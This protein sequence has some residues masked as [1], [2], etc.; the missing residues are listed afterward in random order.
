VT[1]RKRPALPTYHPAEEQDDE[2][3]NSF[4]C[5]TGSPFEDEVQTFIRTRALS[6]ALADGEGY[7]L[8]LFHDD[9]RLIGVAGH[10]P[11]ILI[12][13]TPGN[14]E[15]RAYEAVRLSVLA[16]GLADQ[17]RVL[18]DGR[19]LSDLVMETLIAEA[20]G[21]RSSVLV[22]GVVARANHRSIALCER[23]KLRSQTQYDSL[24][25]RVSGLFTRSPS[26]SRAATLPDR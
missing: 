16:L 6:L 20:I 5:S 12:A 14:P 4:E 15:G 7:E 2:R 10:H 22:S 18:H 25:L 24:H 21:G 9:D 26:A 19:R 11:E 23:H 3:L 1:R 8:L 17:G 13:G